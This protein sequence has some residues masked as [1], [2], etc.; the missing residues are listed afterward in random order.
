MPCIIFYND[1]AAVINCSPAREISSAISTKLEQI[2]LGQGD[3]DNQNLQAWSDIIRWSLP[4]PEK[5]AFSIP[6]LSHNPATN[7]LPNY[8]QGLNIYERIKDNVEDGIRY[9]AEDCD[10]MQV[11]FN[12]F[13]ARFYNSCLASV[14]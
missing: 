8:G 12:F 13:Y 5:V 6:S 14:T 1:F 9:Y 3:K 4:S 11:R 10:C 7:N 2:E